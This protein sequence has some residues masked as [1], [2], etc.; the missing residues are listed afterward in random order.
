MIDHHNVSLRQLHQESVAAADGEGDWPAAEPATRVAEIAE[1]NQTPPGPPTEGVQFDRLPLSFAQERLW[2]LNELMPGSAV[3]NVPGA[4]RIRGELDVSH[5]E[6]ALNLIIARHENLRTVFPSEQGRPRQRILDRFDL[7]FERIDLSRLATREARDREAQRLCRADAA[8]PFDLANGPLLRGQVIKLS[9]HEHILMLNMHHIISDGW[10]T[11][12]LLEELGVILEAFRL[13][14]AP[15][16]PPLPIQYADYSVWQRQWL[17]EGGVLAEQLAYWQT[18]LAGTPESLDLVLDFPRP[19]VPT[20]AGASHSFALDA[21]LTGLLK[22]VAEQHGATLYMALLATFKVLLYRYTGQNDLCVGSPIANRQYGETEGLIG[23]F[24]N[25]L[26]MRTRVEGSDTFVELLA[27]VRATCLEAYENQDAPFEKVVDVLQLQRSL[28]ISPLFQ[29]MLILQNTESVALDASIEPYVV[30]GDVS[31][32]ELTLEFRESP[33]GLMGSIRYRT[34][35]YERQTI[36]RMAEHFTALVRAIVASPAARTQDLDYL[37]DAEI[38]QLLTVFNGAP[39]NRVRGKC[40]HDLF[41]EQVARGGDRT[42]VVCGAERLTY[43]QLEERSRELALVLQSEGVGPDSLVGLCVERSLDMVV[44]LLGILRAGGAY[45][46]LDPDYPDERI[47][48]MVRDSQ[49]AIVLTQTTLQGR[50]RALIPGETRLVALDR[51]WPEIAGRAAALSARQVRLEQWIE[52]HH[53]AYVIYTSGSTGRPK[54]VM[55]EHGHV[56][57]YVAA[58]QDRLQIPEGSSFGLVSTFAAD[59]GNTVLFPSLLG[60]GTLHILSGETSTDAA[61]YAAYCRNNRIDCLKVTPSHLQ[62][63]VGEL[64]DP[65]LIPAHT[66]VLGGEVSSPGVVNWIRGINPACRIFNHYGPTECTVGVLCGEAPTSSGR[67]VP[68]GA[69]LGG[70]RIYIVDGQGRPVPMGVAG[71][72]HIGGG[73]V[74]RGYRNRP[75]LTAERFVPDRFSAQAGARVYK[76]GDMARWRADGTV[77]YLGRNDFQV[78]IRGFRVEPGE[79]AAQLSKHAS[80]KEAVVIARE[81]DPAAK[82]L[83]AYVTLAEPA[84]VDELR[85]HLLAR[86]PQY[87][88]PATFVIL[89]A[90]P[91][92]PNG[93][94]DRKALP[95][96]E[97]PAYASKRYEPPQGRI[98]ETLAAIWQELLKVERPGRNDNFFELGGH[99]LLATRLVSKIRG[100]LGVELPLKAIFEDGTV[101]QLAERIARAVRSDI[102]PIRPV[103]RTQLERLP[104]SFAQERLWF[105]NQLAPNTAGYNIPRAVRIRGALDVVQV[106]EALDFVIAR[107]ENLRTIFPSHEGQAQQKILDAVDFT[108]ARI[109]LS[110]YDR[111]VRDAEAKRLCQSEAATLFDLANGPLIRGMVIK[112]GEDEHILML[113]LH[114]IISDG[115]SHGVLIRE[116]NAVMEAWREGR[117]PDLPL[118]PIQ[119]ADYSV[120]QRRW[121]EES[122]VLE[123]QLGYWQQKL[124]WIPES[125]AL[126]TDFPRPSVQTYAGANHL[127]AIDAELTAR[128]KR[129]AEQHGGT[130]YMV[131]LAAFKALLHRYTGQNDICVGSAIANRQYGETEGLIGMFVNTLAM[132]SQVEGSDSFAALLAKVKTTCLEAYEHQDAPFERVV[133]AL[134][135]QRNLAIA[136]LFQVML[137]LQNTERPAADASIE[138]YPLDGGISKFDLTV[139]FSNTPEG[140]DA[141]IEYN[142][143]LYEAETIARMARHFAALCEAITAT[144]TAEVRELDYLGEAEKHALLVEYNASWADYPQGECLHQLFIEQV[145]AHAEKPA[146]L[147][148][149][150]QLTYQQLYARSADLALYLQS[151]GVQP[152]LLVGVCMERSLDMIVGLLGILQAGG[153]Y[154]PLDP[155][156]PDERLAYMVRDSRAGV[157]LTQQ[158]LQRQLRA[159]MPAE[160]QLIELDGQCEEIERRVAELKASGA[161]LRQEVTPRNLSHIIYT[162]GSTGQPKGV[163]IEHHSPVTLLHWAREI[164][165]R[166]ELSGVLGST[167]ICF[168]LSVYE[169]F[170]TLANGG[171]V[172]LVDNALGLINLA[173]KELVTLI[174]TVPSAMEEL[175]RVGAIPPSVKTVNLAGEPLSRALVDRIYET[176]SVEKVYDLYGPSEDTT[177]S[178]YVLR[179]KNGPQ[180]I[181]R[182]IANTEVYILDRNGRLQ[183]IGVPGELHISGDGL[184]REYLNRP[185]L[186]QEKFVENPFRRGRRMYRTGDLA[187]WLDDGTIQYLGRIDTQV[188]VRGF[189]IEMGEIEARLA[190][191][192]AIQDVA[193]VARGEGA[194][195]Q[196][197]AFYR[198]KATTAERLAEVPS[199]ELRGHLRNTLP[200]YMVPSAF[201][202]LAAIPLNPNGKVDRRTLAKMDVSMSSRRESVGP[203]SE[204]E[205]RLTAVWAEVLG[206]APETIGVYDNFFELGG[207][208]LLATQVISKIRGQMEIELPLEALFERPTVAEIAELLGA[209]QKSA[210]PAMRPIDRAQY[211]RLPLSFAQERLWFI[212]Q[213]EPESPSYNLPSAVVIRG[214]LDVDQ[215]ET[216]FNAVIARHENL[217]TVFPSENGQARQ[218]ILERLDFRLERTDVSHEAD[219]HD[220]AKRICRVEVAA[221][222]DLALGP[223]IRGKVIRLAD[224][225]HV[226]M[227]NMHHIVSDGWSSGVLMRELGAI[228]QALREGRQPELPPLPIQY[229]D[230]AVWQREWLERGGVLERQLGYWQRKLAGAPEN[231]ELPS[232]YPRPSVA[233]SAGAAYRFGIDGELTGRLKRLAEQHG[234]TLFIVVL[235]AFKGLLHRYSGQEDICVGSPIANR[236]YGETEGLIGMFVNTLALR[237][238]IEPDGTF[239][240]LVGKVKATCLEAY[241]YQDA[242][243]EKV[244]D[245]LR[246]QRSLTVSPLF[247]VMLVLQNSDRS[248]V[249]ALIEPYPLESG[250][251]KFD[252]TVDLTETAEGLAGSVRYRT[253]LFAAETIERMVRHLIAFCEA[254]AGDPA[255]RVSEIEL[256]SAEEQHRLLVENNATAAEYPADKCVHELFAEQAEANPDQPAVVYGEGSLTYQQLYAKS[257]AVAAYLRTRGVEPDSLV[258][259]YMERSI[260]MVVGMMAIVQAGGAYVPLDPDYPAERLQTM[261][262]DAS[263]TIV[264]TQGH[265]KDRLTV[266]AIALDSEWSEI[267]QHWGSS[268]A[269]AVTPDNLAYVIYTSGSTGMPKGVMVRHQGVVNLHSALEKAVYEGHPEWRRVSVNASFAFDSSVKQF[270]QLLSGRTLVMVPQDVRLDASALLRFIEEQRID[271]FDCTPS[272]LRAMI[273]EGMFD[274]TRGM[275]KAM[276]IGGEAIERKL[277]RTLGEHPEVAFYN[278]YGPAECTVDA[279]VA[280]VKAEE[281]SPHIGKPVGNARIY[282]VDRF[283]KP[284]PEGVVGEICIGGVGVA[285]GYW[286][287]PELTAERFFESRFGRLYRSGDLGRWRGD[288]NIEFSGRND[289]QVKLR[290]QRIELGEIEAQLCRHERVREAVVIAREDEP[291]EKR[292]VAYVTRSSGDSIGAEELRAHLGKVLPRYMVP[293]AYVELEAL[294]LTPNKK[295]DRKGLPKPEGEAYARGEYE[296]PQGRVEEAVAAIWKELL[297]VERVGRNDNFF[298]LGGHSLSAVQLMAKVN[299]QFEQKLPLSVLFTAS[300]VAALAEMIAR[301]DVPPHDIVVAI[302]PHGDAPPVFA[303]PGAG[304]NVLSLRPLIRVLGE[305]QPLFALQPVGIDGT[306]A[307][308]ESVEQAARANVAALKR[309]QPAGPYSLIGHS[310]GG[311]V[312]YEMARLLLEEGEEVSSLVLLDSLAPG[313]MQSSPARDEMTVLAEAVQSLADGDGAALEIHVERLRRMSFDE[314]VEYAV[315]LLNERGFHIT[316]EQFAAFYRVYRSDL[317][318]YR[319]YRPSLLPRSIDVSLYRATRHRSDRTDL[320]RDYGWDQLLR[321]PVRA[322]DVDADHFTI[323]ERVSLRVLEEDAAN[324]VPAS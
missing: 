75:E 301:H 6:Q 316:A 116:L 163:A 202:S 135:V 178:T 30:D 109:D 192:G 102:P 61:A 46:P 294:P 15:E 115:W 271:V 31:K 150:E 257:S 180:T 87:M 260:E 77:E 18:K 54:G 251:S 265:L 60:G 167:S 86:V 240:A 66:L 114:H 222:F 154:V 318:S 189:R 236:R 147:C 232:D 306:K 315:A 13:G 11:G 261:L 41:A 149:D 74:A 136:P 118:L 217:R 2:F 129:I 220:A 280:R 324:I 272:Q 141:L 209:A 146:V 228:L 128:L 312:A 70:T 134:H 62:A 216:A 164:Y 234:A 174:N 16:L 104:L 29:V 304:G 25:T 42:A 124:A 89:D 231:L 160:T 144:P 297:Q 255:A 85:A 259:L 248:E 37:G 235:A 57:R 275:P 107:H 288:G 59:L 158:S 293:A 247:Q 208:S 211:E 188:K 198:A 267:E 117:R 204:T 289:D 173:Q 123:R 278:V 292:L 225:E 169:I 23:L 201:V 287:R 52:P 22:R 300:T 314:R 310:Y 91:L 100:A 80:V 35:L 227:L 21:Q 268:S 283:G 276:L 213:L 284:V 253:S 308:L 193:V 200:E 156:Y 191:H 153:A 282:M 95:R 244:I 53:L 176:T 111:E 296:A 218:R 7:E 311:L 203:R 78:K 33:E 71:E 170:V 187:R 65:R 291:G 175:V 45:V 101:V 323:L 266:P 39:D 47:A 239:A 64:T 50:L 181:G 281:P 273:E 132:R 219:P 69:P 179:E 155:N 212:N 223:L 14:R 125:L 43:Q 322:A 319:N 206:R 55:V 285:R 137:I 26:A 177:Y 20:Y 302:Q 90:M 51:E 3:Y 230:Y 190:E 12:V 168:D 145:A 68:L 233:T 79:I 258:G 183:P 83:V 320:P 105:L 122:G 264:V 112:L 131:L 67:S 245:A 4:G 120:W 58:V 237:T 138:L 72:L 270:V 317:L 76:T 56:V 152:D 305:Q 298:E 199:E 290:G 309:V 97:A 263:P 185:E 295:V 254:A 133:D 38:H 246:L 19:E 142:T 186:T 161:A 121:L 96:P 99:S 221:L 113:N 242:P 277:W 256:L 108:L 159:I 197:I 103:D 32:F 88:V 126:P 119:Y 157:V 106:E 127:F 165:S 196:L 34:A 207:H 269:T 262:E 313:V 224:D 274:G 5:V 44:G 194:N 17:E 98:E 36:A 148:G 94:V 140:L 286:K 182:P 215:L 210:V 24:I 63:L 229:A 92:T 243:F 8:R 130:L 307:P 205:R 110:G 1:K 10:S 81:D 249:D 162:S 151:L 321:V 82:R 73:Q 184:A 252:L 40:L 143:A 48:Y 27:K 9:E 250:V 226:L 241:E 28:A 238:Q 84:G 93:K 171:T 49:A 195:K 172:I 139:I 299:R 166:E 214:G 303:I 279:T